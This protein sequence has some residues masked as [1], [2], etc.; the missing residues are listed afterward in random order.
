MRV[1]STY[2]PRGSQCSFSD[3]GVISMMSGNPRERILIPLVAVKMSVM[4][5][6]FVTLE[7]TRLLGK[8]K[9]CRCEV[10]HLLSVSFSTFL[11]VPPS[12]LIPHSSPAGLYPFRVLHVLS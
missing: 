7:S 6:P 8:L 4:F 2:P 1:P 9:Q 10:G 3:P 11:L 12:P 5:S